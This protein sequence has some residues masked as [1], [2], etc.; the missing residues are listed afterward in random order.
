MAEDSLPEGAPKAQAAPTSSP[1]N[2]EQLPIRMLASLGDA[3][4]GLYERERA[5]KSCVTAKQ[6]HLS[7]KE[8]VNATAQA[9]FL[10]EITTHLNENELDL[11]RRARNLKAGN[12]RNSDQLLYRKATALEALVGYLHLRDPRRLETLL[13]AVDKS[14]IA[15]IDP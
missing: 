11:V 12:Y 7:V 4:I 3:V 6:M 15:H 14:Q 9:S 10:D 1:E 2:Y 13:A 8:R 5:F